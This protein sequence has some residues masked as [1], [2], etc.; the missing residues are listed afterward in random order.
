MPIGIGILMTKASVTAAQE[1]LDLSY[2]RRARDHSRISIAPIK[3]A[4]QLYL[5]A[6]MSKCADSVRDNR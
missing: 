6:I 2:F 3:A 5:S 4:N 1:Q